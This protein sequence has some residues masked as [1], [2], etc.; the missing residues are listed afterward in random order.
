MEALTAMNLT[1]FQCLFADLAPAGCYVA[2]RV[3]FYAPEAEM[4]LFSKD[5]IDHYTLSGHALADPFLLWCQ[6]NSGYARW[7]DFE[8]LGST[9]VMNDYRSFGFRFGGVFSIWGSPSSPKRSLG[10]FARNDREFHAF[11]MNEI[12]ETL[13]KIHDY[14][15][16]SLTKSQLEALR[17]YSRGT[18]QKQIAHELNIS[19]PA[20]K[21]RLRSAAIRLE[22][23][24]LREAL[25]IAASR[26]L[27]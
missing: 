7:S 25:H 8:S 27:L 11:E 26:G 20:V 6:K 13:T 21:A 24:T 2:L 16:T 12:S 4:N 9:K 23:K 15:Q 1:D 22:V 10:I 14:K 5:W 18:L 19:L 17:L 3:G